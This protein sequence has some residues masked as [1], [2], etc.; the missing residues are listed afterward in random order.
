MDDTTK[1]EIS[2]HD[3]SQEFLTLCNTAVEIGIC[4]AIELAVLMLNKEGDADA[5]LD[6]LAVWA[7]AD[8]NSAP[9][10]HIAFGRCADAFYLQRS[11]AKAAS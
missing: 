11:Q 2:R 8:R 3:Y 1:T 9:Q 4:D 5:M 6:E 10:K 7:Y